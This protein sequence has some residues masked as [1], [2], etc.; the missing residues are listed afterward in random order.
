M[1]KSPISHLTA[2]QMPILLKETRI[3]NNLWTDSNKE[4]LVWQNW[5][6]FWEAP[7]LPNY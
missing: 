5:Q 7:H 4:I 6:N 1:A 2:K 3:Q